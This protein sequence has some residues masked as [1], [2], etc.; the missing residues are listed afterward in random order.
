MTHV[1]ARWLAWSLAGLTVAL[2]AAIFPLFVLVNRT[3]VP[4]SWDARETLEAFTGR[5]RNETDL[6]V[7]GENLVSVVHNTMQPEHASLWLRD[8]VER[9][10][11]ETRS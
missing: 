7:L 8:Q 10:S 5:L 9:A 4:E 1:S 11:Q 3:P 6:D 2:Y